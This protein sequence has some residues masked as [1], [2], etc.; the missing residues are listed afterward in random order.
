MLSIKPFSSTSAA[1]TYYTHGDYYGSE[2]EGIWFGE[3][4]KELNLNHEFAAKANKEFDSLLRGILPNGQI[5]GRRTK[6][7]LEHRPGVDLTFSAPKSFSIQMLVYSDPEKK[8]N[9]EQALTNAVNKTLTYI[10][11]EG[12][13]IARKGQGG[14]YREPVN[15]LIFATFIHTTNRNLEPQAHIHSFLANVAKCADEKYRS[16]TIDHLLENNKF[17]GQIFRNELAL[18][19]Q[20]LGY[21]INATI[22]SDGSSSFELSDIDPKLI[23]AFSTRRQ[24]IV[25]LCKLYGVTTKEGRDNIVINSRK[26]KRF[27]TP[28][29]LMKAWCEVESNIKKEIKNNTQFKQEIESSNNQNYLID[30]TITLKDIALLATEDISHSKAVF[31]KEELLKKALKYSIGKYSIHDINQEIAKL[32]KE[33]LL[34]GDGNYFTTKAMI[35]KERQILKYAKIS[36]SKSKPIIKYLD[37]HLQKFEKRELAKNSNFQ[38]NPSQQK[39]VKHILNSRDQII[40]MEGLPGVGKST[41][42]NA[43]RDISK[44]KIISL[45]GLGENFK[46]IAPTASAAKTLKE[47]ANIESQTL[48]SFLGRYQGYIEDRGT[49][50]SLKALKENYKNTI[51]FLDEASLV[52]TNIM[53]KLLKLQSKLGFRLVLTGDTKQLSAVE[54]GKPFEQIL[55]IVKPIKLQDIIRQQDENHRQAIIEASQGN[56]DRSFTIYNENIKQIDKNLLAKSAA[57]LYVTKNPQQRANTL[58]LAPTRDLRDKINN[59]IRILLEQQNSEKAKDFLALRRKDMS[60]ADYNF[61]SS[62]K[63]GDIVKFN[64]KYKTGNNNINKGYY[65]KVKAI[66]EITNSLIL[67]RDGKELIFHLKRNIDYIGKLELFTELNLKLREGLKIIFTKNNKAYGLIN[68]ETAIIEK[69]GKTELCVRF[70]SGKSKT[71]PLS[72]LKHIDYG[73]CVTVHNAQGKT[74]DNTI[75]T[76]GNN[77]LLN[78]QNSWVVTL[79]RHK[80]EF[81]ALVEDKSRLQTHLTK[82]KEIK[83]S[84][85]EMQLKCIKENN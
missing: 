37:Y 13:V 7:G 5:I 14:K 24:E 62:Y 40:T 17:F 3:G 47:S 46:G 64:K 26:A 45:I 77:K 63:T 2:G 42:L 60:K 75:A 6:E 19:T 4:A 11:K 39:A 36:L 18:E 44:K 73:Y 81:T 78:T 8:K 67:D 85:T 49:K 71:I 72:E 43:V 21:N 10:E 59:E 48:H 28:D 12:Y 41:V 83:E 15:K 80:N 82:S 84:A 53:H 16:I 30:T 69:I 70:E 56:I 79:S 34:I 38:I 31:S 32:E 29:G 76:I 20:K 65:L 23:K 57:D 58:L 1:T 68:S 54:A 51:I 35:D 9:L 55:K 22:L 25:E 50:E 74:Y 27:V 61:A 52:S 66:N 33:G